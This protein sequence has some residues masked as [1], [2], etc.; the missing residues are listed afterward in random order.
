M[1]NFLPLPGYLES[2]LEWD[3]CE[4]D[5]EHPVPIKAFTNCLK[6][7]SELLTE[8][9][10]RGEDIEEIIQ[11]RAA[12]VDRVLGMGWK[13]FGLDQADASLVAVGGY[14]RG[15]LHPASDIDLLLLFRDEPSGSEC[16]WP[17][18][19]PDFPLGYQVPGRP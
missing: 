5:P 12:M 9:F 15:E 16:G 14:G 18:R 2:S 19:L 13:R 6:K 7:A 17:L 1:D 8:A 10:Q 4:H 11:G 3:A